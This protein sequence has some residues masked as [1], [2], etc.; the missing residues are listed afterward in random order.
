MRKFHS[1]P[2]PRPHSA[3]DATSPLDADAPS[4]VYRARDTSDPA[5]SDGNLFTDVS[6]ALRRYRMVGIFLFALG[7]TATAFAAMAQRPLYTAEALLRLENRQPKL[8]EMLSATGSL[9]SG[10]LSDTSVVRSEVEYLRSPQLV[11]QVIVSLGLLQRDHNDAAGMHE[12]PAVAKVRAMAAGYL[13]DIS[14]L[15]PWSRTGGEGEKAAQSAP[16]DAPGGEPAQDTVMDRAV[17]DLSH[18][19]QVE[20]VG[21]SYL[22]RVAYRDADPETAAAVV[23][24]LVQLYAD[25]QREAKERIAAQE[26]VRLEKELEEMR[27]ALI[28]SER[29]AASFRDSSE[30]SEVKGV[31]VLGQQV[32]EA[33]QA[34]AQVSHRVQQLQAELDDLRG[35]GGKKDLLSSSRVLESP[36][37][38]RLLVEDAALTREEAEKR[39]SY[40]PRHPATIDVQARREALNSRIRR[41]TNAIEQAVARSLTVAQAEAKA[42][43]QR[44]DDLSQRQGKLSNASATLRDLEQVATAN[45]TMYNDLLN[46]FRLSSARQNHQDADVSVLAQADK[47]AI[48]YSGRLLILAG[49]TVGSATL[50]AAVMLLAFWFRRGVIDMRD[51]SRRTNVRGLGMLPEINARDRKRLLAG[52]N[53]RN[54]VI[55]D[56]ALGI[57]HAL[58]NTGRAEPVRSIMITSAVPEEGKTFTSIVLARALALSG[59]RTLLVDLDCRCPAVEAA[60]Q[61]DIADRSNVVFD[62]FDGAHRFTR[63]VSAMQGGERPMLEYLFTSGGG[64]EILTA[65][66]LHELTKSVQQDFDI[67]I[68]DSPPVLSSPEALVIGRHADYTVLVAR[69]E[70]TPPAMVEESLAT[71]DGAGV[72]V[73]G[74]IMS[75]VD[76][77]KHARYGFN[78]RAMVFKKYTRKYQL[79]AAAPAR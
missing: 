57:I 31:T 75:R 43:Q 20:T 17:N 60:V 37:I 71:L 69:W 76:Y 64:V 11:R 8:A 10:G 50:S 49:G 13:S 78:D 45:R 79:S 32:G 42:L 22:V 36:V 1:V 2:A 63:A 41:E 26:H 61:A 48:G 44:I 16:Q 72:P 29:E 62:S 21:N 39:M 19:L 46:K 18:R 34:L 53:T 30:L 28:D 38:Q 6:R 23:N 3:V 67:V 14:S 51:L 74:I 7:V 77:A 58:A 66:D 68:I 5:S 35:S 56:A 47:P 25:G 40:G 12:H 9:L 52:Q 65:R 55:I 33:T 27:K 15:L 70:K 4:P 24:K 73:E 59:Y 54:T